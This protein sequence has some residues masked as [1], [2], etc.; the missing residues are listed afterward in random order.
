MSDYSN[1]VSW[2]Q[3]LL[4]DVVPDQ[5]DAE[6]LYTCIRTALNRYGQIYERIETQCVQLT[7]A[8]IFAQPL[9]NWSLDQLAEIVYLHWPASSTIAATTSENKIVDYWYYFHGEYVGSSAVQTCYVDLKVSGSTLPAQNDYILV[10]G[11]CEHVLQGMP[12]IWYGGTY[13]SYYSTVPYAHH[14]L[15]A[16]GSAAYALRSR[17]VQLALEA[18]STPVGFGSAYHVGIMSDLAE[19][20]MHDFEFELQILSQKK[21][22]RPVWADPERRRLQRIEERRR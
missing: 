11:V 8:G 16:L 12:L 10:V 21:L 22:H 20:Y 4:G 2:V 7:R 17:E 19:K 1:L 15:I 18:G 13:N 5:W 3:N 9:A 14:G 6:V